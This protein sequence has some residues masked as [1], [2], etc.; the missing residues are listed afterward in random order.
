MA[1]ILDFFCIFFLNGDVKITLSAKIWNFF[2]KIERFVNFFYKIERFLNLF[3]F[4]VK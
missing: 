1:A 2:Y 4:S 3:M